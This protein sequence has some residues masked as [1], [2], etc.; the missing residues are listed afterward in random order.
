MLQSIILYNKPRVLLS[1][2]MVQILMKFS[3]PFYTMLQYSQ[4]L[5]VILQLNLSNG[6]FKITFFVFNTEVFF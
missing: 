2:S 1:I 3:N 6:H 4:T 5:G